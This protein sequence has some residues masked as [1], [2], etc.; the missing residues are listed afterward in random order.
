VGALA[1]ILELYHAVYDGS[2]R[3]G[4]LGGSRCNFSVSIIGQMEG[5]FEA[6]VITAERAEQ[7]IVKQKD[8]V[9]PLDGAKSHVKKL[10]VSK[11]IDT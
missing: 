2:I 4:T 7:L 3:K 1:L 5:F 6:E 8:V 11:I 10:S 9:R